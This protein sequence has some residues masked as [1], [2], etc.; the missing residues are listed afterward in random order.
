MLWWNVKRLN[1]ANERAAISA[2]E[3]LD[4]SKEPRAVDALI[5]ATASKSS[6]LRKAAVIA[7]REIGDARAYESFMVR[8]N[9]E[10]RDGQVE[11][12]K[13]IGKLR[14]ERA[15]GPLM[16][17]LKDFACTD[18]PGGYRAG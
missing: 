18:I 9:D 2:A 5:R 4:A 8:L 12:I 15:I 17:L 11:A 3:R 14:D 1:S 6:K 16:L 10:E 7:L 13:S